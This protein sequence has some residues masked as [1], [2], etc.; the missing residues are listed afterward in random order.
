MLERAE[1]LRKALEE[2]GRIITE[3]KTQLDLQ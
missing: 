1:Q 3:L 2:Q